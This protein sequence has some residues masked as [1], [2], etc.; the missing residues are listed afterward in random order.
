MLYVVAIIG[1]AVLMVVHETGHYLAA[2][3]AGIRVQ[4][5]SIGFGPTFFKIVPKDG[6]YW[7]TSFGDRI[8]ARLFKHDPEK[9][10]PTIFQ[11]AMIPFLAY[12]QIAGMNPLEEIDPKDKGSYA[13]AG[14]FARMSTIFGGPLANYLFASIFFFVAFY[15]D[16]R[17]IPSSDPTQFDV[18]EGRPAKAAGLADGDKVLSIDGTPIHAWEEIPTIVSKKAGVPLDIVV[19]RNGKNETFRVVP[20]DEKGVGR[21]GIAPASIKVKIG[22]GEA[23]VLALESPIIVIKRMATLMVEWARGKVDG[24]LGSSVAMVKEMKKAA[25]DGWGDFVSF[26]GALS[27]YLAIF[28]LLPIPALDGGRLM[29]LGYEAVTRKRPNPTVEAQIHAVGLI[30]MLGLMIYVTFANDLGLF[31][32]K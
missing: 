7:F 4:K 11:V 17:T 3:R 19:E 18:I 8:N 15:F 26:L 9:H 20:E 27:A 10:G 2:R 16:G 28:N 30:M 21:I 29:F 31:P 1:L 12:V 13:N 14:L 24:Q 32:K 25:E 22:A 6:Y 23:A 5:F